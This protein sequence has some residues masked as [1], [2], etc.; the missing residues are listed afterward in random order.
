V[1]GAAGRLAVAVVALPLLVLDLRRLLQAPG[2]EMRSGPW[3]QCAQG[4][5]RRQDDR[6]TGDCARP[7]MLS[8]P[9]IRSRLC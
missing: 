1:R 2:S 5:G 3:A 7:L 8:F 4:S 6:T 9:D